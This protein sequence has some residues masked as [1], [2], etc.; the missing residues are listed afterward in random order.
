MTLIDLPAE[1]LGAVEAEL[2]G[3]KDVSHKWPI[4]TNLVPSSPH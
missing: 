2:T 3:A 1:R 4:V